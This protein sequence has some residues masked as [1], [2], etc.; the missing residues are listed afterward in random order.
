MTNEIFRLNNNTRT[1]AS[2][3]PAGW[4]HDS[5]TLEAPIITWAGKK[6]YVFNYR[7]VGAGDVIEEPSEDNLYAIVDLV[8]YDTINQTDATGLAGTAVLGSELVTIRAGL[9]AGATGSVTVNISTCRA[10]VT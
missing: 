9:K 8:D 4:T 10:T 5:L 2:N 6:H 1:P 7:G 3:R